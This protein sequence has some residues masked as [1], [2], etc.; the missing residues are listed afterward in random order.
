MNPYT[1]RQIQSLSGLWLAILSVALVIAWRERV[2]AHKPAH[3]MKMADELG[4]IGH[5]HSGLYPNHSNTGLLFSQTTETGVGVYF[6][7]A[8]GGKKKLICEQAEKGWSW[9]KYGMLGWSPQW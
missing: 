3:L 1:K 6:C 9:Q 8:T 7:S 5:F 2:V 4:W